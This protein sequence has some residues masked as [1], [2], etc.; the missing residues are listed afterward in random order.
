CVRAQV[1]CKVAPIQPARRKKRK[2]QD[3]DLIDRLKKY[4][5]LM[6]RNGI[7]FNSILVNNH[8]RNASEIASHVQNPSPGSVPPM[9]ADA[10]GYQTHNDL[11]H[12]SDDDEQD[13]PTIH[14]AFDKMFENGNDGFPFRVGGSKSGITHLHP[15]AIQIF[16]LW[17]IYLNNISHVPTLQNKIVNASV[18]LANVAEPLEALMFAIYFISVTSMP[19]DEVEATLGDS[20]N[21]LLARYHAASQ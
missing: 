5:A 3:D 8:E 4:E 13:Q 6:T 12:G 15:S 19:N 10:R 7:D 21:A 17:Q 1:E 11:L 14:H 18:D 2:I 16:Q 9:A 20:K